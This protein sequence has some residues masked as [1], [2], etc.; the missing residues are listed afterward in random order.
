[1]DL[2]YLYFRQQVSQFNADNAGCDSARN[3]HQVMADA[4]CVLIA[5]ERD[6]HEPDV[7]LPSR[8]DA[9][10]QLR[11]QAASCRRLALGAA[12]VQGSET[13]RAVAHQ[14]DAD[15]KRADP[16]MTGDAS[17][18]VASLVRVRL[19]LEHQTAHWL[20]RRPTLSLAKGAA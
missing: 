19:A 2:N 16:A 7:Q 11:A 3:A 13:L 14:F 8:A 4:Y 17:G 5:D 15:A 18:Q 9:A 20:A 12:T 1:M 6:S 10:D